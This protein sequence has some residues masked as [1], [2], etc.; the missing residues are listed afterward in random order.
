MGM[1]HR[2]PEEAEGQQRKLPREDPGLSFITSEDWAKWKQESVP[3]KG[4]YSYL[5]RCFAD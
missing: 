2:D 5:S 1:G 3:E 4:G